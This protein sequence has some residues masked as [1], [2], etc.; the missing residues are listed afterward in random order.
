MERTAGIY[1]RISSDG[2]GEALGVARQ[3]ADARKLCA[4][5]GW[6]VVDVF[7]D[8]DKSAYD[9]R[10]TRTRYRDMLQAVKDGRINAIVA[11]H[12]DRLHRQSRE[13]VGFIDLINERD[14]AVETVTAGR[15]DLSTPAGRMN[16][17]IVGSVAE[18]ESEHK[19]ERIRRKLE[20]NA[21]NGRHHGGSR[22]YGWCDDRVTI[23]PGEA[24]AV[25]EAAHMIMAGES[26]RGVARALNASGYRTSTGKEWRDI[27]VREMLLRPRNAGLRVH[28]GEVVGRGQ[29][30]PILSAEDFHQV[31]AI[32]SNPARRT[33]PGR[34][35]VVH[36][37]SVLAR[38]AVC[39]GPMVVG[40]SKPY[41]GKSKRIYRCRA[42]HV[43]R[44]MAS[45]DE[46]VRSVIVGRLSMPDAADLLSDPDRTDR[47]HA[48]ARRVQEL[49]DRLNDAA[50]AYAAETISLAQLTTINATLRPKLE[51]AQTEAASPN[52]MSVL[53]DLVGAADP[54]A[55]WDELPPS[56]RRAVVDLLL[57]I[58]IKKTSSGPRF[59]PES[60]EIKLKDTVE[61][62]G[63]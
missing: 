28:H 16:A 2:T 11:W 53:G 63:R 15:Y 49:Q 59:D 61:V 44:D 40:K 29:W 3:E 21:A 36:L 18:Y 39:D 14:V 24:A 4:D 6:T 55:V 45:V 58:R 50:E 43:S 25:A 7:S 52:R 35:G 12:P 30:E 62:N 46:L 32:M 20:E 22:P 37:V 60:V 51:A 42:A 57:N 41:K 54:S 9:R 27:T 5:R 10:K 26:V 48:A 56:R 33:N 47:A 13:L 23:N 19:S 38:C 1:C 8:N 17:K 34:D 31:E